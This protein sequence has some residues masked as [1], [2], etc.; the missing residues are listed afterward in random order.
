MLG[1][2]IFNVFLN[3]IY[4]KSIDAE[5]N[6]K[7]PLTQNIF[8]KSEMLSIAFFSLLFAFLLS[9]TFSWLLTLL[10]ILAVITGFIYSVPPF[11]IRRF[12]FSIIIVSFV[13]SSFFLYGVLSAGGLFDDK[14]NSVRIF[15]AIF[16]CAT[17]AFNAKDLKDYKGDKKENVRNLVTVLG[18]KKAK[19]LIGFL[20][21]LSFILFPILIQYYNYYFLAIALFLSFLV[22]YYFLSSKRPKEKIFFTIG[23]V[24]CMVFFVFQVFFK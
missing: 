4:D 14:M 3:D 12:I 13:E 1:V 18:Y 5:S 2:W 21:G 15:L 8:T 19:I 9:L 7:R 17:L 6:I 22:F 16:I 24:Y 23:F 11:R 10:V 20:I